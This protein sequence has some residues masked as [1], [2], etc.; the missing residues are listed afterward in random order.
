MRVNAETNR[1]KSLY[2]TDMKCPWW[3]SL[4]TRINL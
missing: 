1:S 3:W 4:V 2:D